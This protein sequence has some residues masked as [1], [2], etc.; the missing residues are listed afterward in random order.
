[1]LD[2]ASPGKASPREPLSAYGMRPFQYGLVEVIPN[3]PK[4]LQENVYL[5]MGQNG[6]VKT[7]IACSVIGTANNPICEQYSQTPSGVDTKFHYRLKYLPIWQ[8][9]QNN[10]HS[11]VECAIDEAAR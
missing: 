11:F 7:V 5:Q 6:A 1:M 4:E 9:M 2:N 10:I 3:Y 8:E